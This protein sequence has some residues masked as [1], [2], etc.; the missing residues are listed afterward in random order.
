[1][2]KLTRKEI[3]NRTDRLRQTYARYEG[4]FKRK[5]IWL[6]TCVTCGQVLPCDKTNG[7]HFIPR[8]CMPYRWDE[9]NVHCQCVACNLWKNGSYIE[10]SQWFMKKYGEDTFDRYV[11]TYRKWRI[12]KMP[13]LKIDEIKAYY[14][15]WL[16][17]CRQLEKKTSLQ[18][19]PKSWEPFGEVY[20][21]YDPADK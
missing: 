3:I 20:L 9:K 21:D 14:N 8:G 6:N 18:L 13:A 2:K 5:G 1:M 11:E 19:F 17:K 15:F 4:A 7:G 12:G 16:T 10:Y